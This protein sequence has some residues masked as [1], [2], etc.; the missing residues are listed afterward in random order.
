[1][2]LENNQDYLSPSNYN[3][4]LD[5][6]ENIRGQ[7]PDWSNMLDIE[8]ELDDLITEEDDGTDY[9]KEA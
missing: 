3:K 6:I 7:N 1:M 2:L 5:E 4:I 8:K 9:F